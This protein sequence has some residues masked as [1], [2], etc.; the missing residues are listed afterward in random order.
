MD[1]A[2]LESEEWRRCFGGLDSGSNEE[3]HGK[4]VFNSIEHNIL[5]IIF[6]INYHKM[7]PSIKIRQ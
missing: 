2:A 3:E 6:V 1:L 7:Y 5:V 4:V